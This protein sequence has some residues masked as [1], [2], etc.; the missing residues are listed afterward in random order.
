MFPEYCAGSDEYIYDT[1]KEVMVK[2]NDY[3]DLIKANGI[4]SEFLEKHIDEIDNPE[5]VTEKNYESV[6]TEIKSNGVEKTYIVVSAR[7]VYSLR[8]RQYVRHDL[9]GVVIPIHFADGEIPS[10]YSTQIHVIAPN[11]VKCTSTYKKLKALFTTDLELKY[12]LD[13]AGNYLKISTQLDKSSE[14]FPVDICRYKD[15]AMGTF[16]FLNVPWISYLSD[17]NVTIK[18]SPMNTYR[19]LQIALYYMQIKA[20]IKTIQSEVKLYRYIFEIPQGLLNKMFKPIESQEYVALK[21]CLYSGQPY[22][23]DM[24]DGAFPTI[25]LFYHEL[26]NDIYNRT[27]TEAVVKK[28]DKILAFYNSEVCSICKRVGLTNNTGVLNGP[29]A[30]YPKSMW[31]TKGLTYALKQLESDIEMPISKINKSYIQAAQYEYDFT[32][33]EVEDEYDDGYRDSGRG[34]SSS[35]LGDVATAAIGGK[36]ANRGVE[37]QLKEQNRLLREQEREQKRANDM[38]E[39]EIARLQQ[40]EHHNLLNGCNG[41]DRE[42][43][44]CR[45]GGYGRQR[46]VR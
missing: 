6:L 36:I 18:Y 25:T 19:M 38:R 32:H 29:F 39:R 3:E 30:E 28:I 10:E 35:F 2:T 17:R 37:K 13:E 43:A 42:I 9:N 21:N 16:K 5:I 23:L 40:K 46:N 15:V 14:I 45:G 33:P 34:G 20:S 26:P 44:G 1:I 22:T 41:C 11:V 27:I 8:F 7:F 31:G 24:I 4:V 12:I